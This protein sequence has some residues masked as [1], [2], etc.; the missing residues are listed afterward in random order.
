MTASRVSVDCNTIATRAPGLPARIPTMARTKPPTGPRYPGARPPRVDRA[1][2]AR[3]AARM[4]PPGGTQQLLR[5][6]ALMPLTSEAPASEVPS[7]TEDESIFP[8][9]DF[10]L[11]SS[12]P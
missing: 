1:A 5:K 7:E 9:D 6:A 12:E 11:A 8:E 10:R 2:A 4:A 3:K